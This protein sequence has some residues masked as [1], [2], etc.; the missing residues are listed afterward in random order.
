MKKKYL[1]PGFD[2]IGYISTADIISTSLIDGDPENN[3]L[4]TIWTPLS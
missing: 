1:S 3:E 2:Y 4:P